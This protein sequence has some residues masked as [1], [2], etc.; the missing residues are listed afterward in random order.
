MVDRRNQI[1]QTAVQMIADEGYASL[2]MRALARA[3]G[4]KLG[5]LQYHFRTSE[6]MWRAVV[7]YIGESYRCSF[8]SLRGDDDSLGVCRGVQAQPTKSAEVY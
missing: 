4:M 7:G 3:V 6:E 1:L 5:A 8:M 2:T